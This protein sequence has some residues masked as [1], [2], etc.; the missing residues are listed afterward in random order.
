MR[1]KF[2]SLQNCFK[3]YR[4]PNSRLETVALQ[5]LDLEINRGEIV[6]IVGPSGS[7]KST[8]LNLIGGLDSP[9]AGRIVHNSKKE[10]Y[11]LTAMTTDQ[12]DYYR[13]LN[14]GYLQQKPVL[15]SNY[16]AL[17]N[18]ELPLQT[19]GNLKTKKQAEFWLEK[20]GLGDR[21][22]S[23]PNQLSGG[24][25]QR[26]SLASALVFHPSLLLADEPTAEVDS[27]TAKQIIE[28]LQQLNRELNI[29]IVIVTHDETIA[30]T[31][32]TR[33]RLEDGMITSRVLLE[34]EKEFTV[35]LDEF[36]R[37][38]IPDVVLELLGNPSLL[39]L[40]KEDSNRFDMLNREQTEDEDLSTGEIVT[41]D[42]NGRI[43]FPI[44]QKQVKIIVT[45]QSVAMKLKGREG[46]F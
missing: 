16:T 2:I 7:G 31:G 34:E 6:S 25:R 15:M 22:H 19:R 40:R 23:K 3:I 37:I 32:H 20:L 33:F 43:Y 42:N 41:V 5:K 12:R 21:L 39:F 17:E 35:K 9:S 29:T 38:K 28:L 8:L 14:V 4:D 30:N 36:N 1:E 24:E 27:N 11:D 18:V 46:E 26:V 13:S 45:K 10:V 44:N